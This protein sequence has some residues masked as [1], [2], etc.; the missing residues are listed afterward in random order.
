MVF[1][2]ILLIILLF[3]LFV[4]IQI[5]LYKY[6]LLLLILIFPWY[7][8]ANTKL[9]SWFFFQFCQWHPLQKKKTF[10]EI[11][12]ISNYYFNFD[13]KILLS[14]LLRERERERKKENTNKKDENIEYKVTPW[15]IIKKRVKSGLAQ[16]Y[17][18]ILILKNPFFQLWKDII[19]FFKVKLYWIFTLWFY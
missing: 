18:W 5:F 17:S 12:L 13:I 1:R 7:G 6:K 16:N 3:I 4:F 10:L 14:L 19:H 11:N 2:K 8:L 9:S 15:R